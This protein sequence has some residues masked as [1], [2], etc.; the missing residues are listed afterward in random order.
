MRHKRLNAVAVTAFFVASITGIAERY[1]ASADDY[2]CRHVVAETMRTFQHPDSTATAE[3]H[4]VKAGQILRVYEDDAAHHRYRINVDAGGATYFRLWVS[5]DPQWTQPV[6]C[7][8][9]PASGS[10]AGVASASGAPVAGNVYSNP[11]VPGKKIADPGVLRDHGAYYVYATSD[12]GAPVWQMPVYETTDLH[13]W[14]KVGGLLSKPPTWAMTDHSFWA[15][16]VRPINGKYV[17]FYSAR[18][19][20]KGA[21][22]EHEN[23]RGATAG[24]YVIGIAIA[25]HPEGPFEPRS[26]PIVTNAA[27]GLIDPTFFVD[28]KDNKAYLAWKDDTNGGWKD[29]NGHGRRTVIAINELDTKTWRLRWPVSREI[30]KRSR[31]WEGSVVEAPSFIF[32]DGYYYLFYSG[33]GYKKEDNYAVGVLRARSILGPYCA[34][35]AP[36]NCHNSYGGE[37]KGIEDNRILRGDDKV[38]SPGHQSLALGPDGRLLMFYHGWTNEVPSYGRQLMMDAVR[39]GLAGWPEIHDGTPS[40]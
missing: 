30:Y 36:S 33:N 9:P 15:P 23:G 27:F 28:P 4:V 34:R 2:T 25:D 39:W 17:A 13:H 11:L 12:G 26:R 1:P 37:E 38:H 40:E 7:V 35:E 16:E 21:A 19:N 14:Q 6:P 20:V 31:D 24:F 5:D 18:L 32:H 3:P 10:A 22:I 8:P 29:A